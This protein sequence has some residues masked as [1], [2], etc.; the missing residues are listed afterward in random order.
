[1][2]SDRGREYYGRHTTYGQI[3]GPF[4]KILEKNGIVAQYSL[5]YEPQQNGVAERRNHTLMDMVCNMLSNSTLPLSFW[6]EALKTDAHI[7][8]HV[9]SKSVSKTPYELW[10]GRKPSIN[11]LHV[12]GC[13]AE[14]KIF[15][16]QLRKLDPKTISC[17]FIGY[18][19]KSKG[20]RFYCPECTTKFADTRHIIFFECDISSSPREIELEEIWTYVP[21]MPTM[22]APHV[23][24]APLA[25]NANSSAENLDAEPT[26]NENEG[27]PLVNEQEGLEE[28]DTS[29]ANDHEEEPQQENDEPQP[30]RRSQR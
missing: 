23:E 9:P 24:N 5:P 30:M 25:E 29:P 10:I 6:M 11:Y 19:E 26:I 4:V 20:Y 1:V 8:N 7:I 17:Y 13:P 21:P 2:R 15:N 18:P 14:A 28:N 27:A 22:D 16:S 3:P 12:W